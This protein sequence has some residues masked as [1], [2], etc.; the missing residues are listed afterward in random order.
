MSAC[1]YIYVLMHLI[2]ICHYYIN[3][4]EQKEDF[5]ICMSD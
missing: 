2:H 4:G 3:A 1:V 5:G